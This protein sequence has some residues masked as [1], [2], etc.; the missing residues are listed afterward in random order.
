[1]KG[2]EQ[3]H[4]RS[5]QEEAKRSVSMLWREGR[6][7]RLEGPAK[8]AAGD[9]GRNGGCSAA[10]TGMALEGEHWGMRGG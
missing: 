7:Q 1:M 5:A 2:R 4:A 10:V 9:K 8:T 3:A 6:E